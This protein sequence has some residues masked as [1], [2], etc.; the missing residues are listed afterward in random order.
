M[1]WELELGLV[2]PSKIYPG[3]PRSKLVNALKKFG[4]L[5]LLSFHKNK[6]FIGFIR[7]FNRMFTLNISKDSN[8]WCIK[9][10]IDFQ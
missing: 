9:I 4:G 2:V 1:N 8:N 3:Y 7:Y 5:Y 6:N 10:L